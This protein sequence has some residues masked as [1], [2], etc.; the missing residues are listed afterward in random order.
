MMLEAQKMIDHAMEL[1][2]MAAILGNLLNSPM[3]SAELQI[4][5]LQLLG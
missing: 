2:I 4:L 3:M 5:L 1:K